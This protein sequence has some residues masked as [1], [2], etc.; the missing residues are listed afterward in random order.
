M[1]DP[2][3]LNLEETP[4]RIE[5]FLGELLRLAGLQLTFQVNR[6]AGQY[7][8]DFENPDLVVSFEGRDTE[9]LLANKAELLIALEHLTMEALHIGTGSREHILFDCQDYRMVRVDELQLAAQAAAERVRRTG[10][11]YE[12]NSMS[13]RERRI[14]HMALRGEPGVHTESEGM[15]P[16]RHVIIRSTDPKAAKPASKPHPPSR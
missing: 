9:L 4:K 15:G 16:R 2:S 8:R 12:F 5:A 3:A 1:A 10:V 6:T 14:I 11:A 13:S 7:N